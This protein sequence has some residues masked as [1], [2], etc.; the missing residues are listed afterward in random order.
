MGV[1]EKLYGLAFKGIKRALNPVK[2]RVIRTECEVHKFINNQSVV[3]LENDGY[4]DAH[5]LMS[6]Y[7]E[8]IN[9]GVVWADQDLKSSN[10]FYSP[11]S[12]RG[13]YGNS[14][15][16]KECLAYYHK[17]LNEYFHCDYHCAMFYLGAACHLIQDLTVPQHA[18]VRLLDNHRSFEKWVICAYKH[19]DEFRVRRG[20]IYLKSLKRY[21]TMNSCK[22]IDTYKRYERIRDQEVRFHKIAQKVL[23]MAQKTT[24]GLMLSFFRDIQRIKPTNRYKRMFFKKVRLPAHS[25]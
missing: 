8:D 21:I 3:I 23:V 12:F 1:T 24:A 15:A 16:K 10:H 20:G 11:H 9:A 2:K 17:A 19:H 25:I 5:Q 7:I 4:H 22:A 18:N 6:S 13:L 14:N